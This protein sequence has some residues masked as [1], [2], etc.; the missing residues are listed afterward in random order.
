MEGTD[1]LK[2]MLRALISYD[3]RNLEKSCS[4]YS[5][6]LVLLTLLVLLLATVTRTALATTPLAA[7]LTAAAPCD[8][9]PATAES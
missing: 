1:S 9:V 6:Y 7:P 4:D 8:P 5:M 3:D 2:V